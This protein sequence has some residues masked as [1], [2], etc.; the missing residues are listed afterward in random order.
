MSRSSFDSTSSS[1]SRIC[2]ASAVSS[3]SDDVSPKW[4]HRPAAPMGP[5]IAWTNAATS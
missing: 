4:I 3:R 2:N 5:A 1:A